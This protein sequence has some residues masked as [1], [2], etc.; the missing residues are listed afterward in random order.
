MKSTWQTGLIGVFFM[1]GLP[2]VA[3]A[4]LVLATM[5]ADAYSAAKQ[6]ELGRHVTGKYGP[7]LRSQGI[8]AIRYE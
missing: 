5:E 8:T 2:V 1:V 4:T 6:A 3:V 7:W